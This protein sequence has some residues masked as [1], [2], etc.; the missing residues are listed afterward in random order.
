MK[1]HHKHEGK[2]LSSCVGNLR[3]CVYKIKYTNKIEINISIHMQIF[4]IH[5]THK[6]K[7]HLTSNQVTESQHLQEYWKGDIGNPIGKLFTG[8]KNSSYFYLIKPYKELKRYFFLIDTLLTILVSLCLIMLVCIRNKMLLHITCML[9]ILFLQSGASLANLAWIIY[10]VFI[11][12]I[13]NN[14]DLFIMVLD[15]SLTL[16][17]ETS[18]HYPLA[19]HIEFLSKQFHSDIYK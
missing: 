19:N 17:L 8:K 18:L 2:C 14:S 16:L 7:R 15:T 13:K 6:Q 12:F 11:V 10:L 1:L 3:K 9:P 4:T 5:I